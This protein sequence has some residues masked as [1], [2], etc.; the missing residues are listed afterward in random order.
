MKANFLLFTLL[1]GAVGLFLSWLCPGIHLKW[2]V[3]PALIVVLFPHFI[4]LELFVLRDILVRRKPVIIASVIGFVMS[5]ISAYF[6]SNNLLNASPAFV[7]IGFTLFAL[8]PGNALAP[9]F[10]KM[11]HGDTS[12]SVLICTVS[13]I[14]AIIFVPVWSQLLLGK[15][16]PIPIMDIVRPFLLIIGVPMLTAAI[17]RHYVMR[18]AGIGGL[19]RIRVWL[20]TA[21]SFGLSVIFFSIFAERG[22]LLLRQPELILKVFPAALLLLLLCLLAGLVL[23]KI[24]RLDRKATEAVVIAG[25]TKNIIIA[26]AL[27]ASAFSNKEAMIVAICGPITQLP[28]M[29]LY[30]SIAGI[31]VKPK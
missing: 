31:L 7:I 17:F 27:A 29:L 13:Y 16:I 30:V 5:P 11:R 9:I 19:Q 23:C 1:P 2:L 4:E 20:H 22:E 14:F 3:I 26:L 18:N 10:T 21:A 24:F 8:V 28:F 25:T 12:L 6:I 15:T